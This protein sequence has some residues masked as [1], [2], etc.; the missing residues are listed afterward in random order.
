MGSTL[1]DQLNYFDEFK[2]WYLKIIRSFNFS[3]EKDCEARNYLSEILHLKPYLYDLEQVLFS[4]KRSLYSKPNIL[5]YGC[6]PSLEKTV[7]YLIK[8]KGVVFFNNF[9]NIAADGAAVLLKEKA[10]PIRAIFSDLDGITQNEFN[11]ACFNIIHAH[12]DN[13]G[14]L[15]AFK[16][17]IIKFE[18]IIGT[19]Q[20]EPVE[21]VL[22][23]GGFT[24]GDRI[25]FF[26]NKLINSSSKL[27]LIGM[28]FKNIIG[29]YS[30][31]SLKR[32]QEGS[33]MKKKKLKFAVE[34]IEWFSTR[35]KNQVFIVNSEEISPKLNYL[36]LDDF[37]QYWNY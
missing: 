7:E 26:L 8:H 19:T 15:I 3:Y 30:K 27:F 35:I 36:Q 28:D 21:N 29:K 14:K 23:P 22:N 1:K 10:I 33:I 20:V 16:E 25:L 31:L 2:D 17:P 34:L 12:G 32:N 9:T 24:D 4:F 13:I 18:K 6:G 11:Y 5:I 37:M